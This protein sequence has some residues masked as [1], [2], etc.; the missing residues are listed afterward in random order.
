MS[1]LSGYLYYCILYF[2]FLRFKQRLSFLAPWFVEIVHF[3]DNF[4][5]WIELD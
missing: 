3:E 5:P 1:F 2:Y 4:T